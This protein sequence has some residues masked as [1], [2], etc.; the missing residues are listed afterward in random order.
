[1]QSQNETRKDKEI[2]EADQLLRKITFPFAFH[3]VQVK[4]SFYS[5]YVM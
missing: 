4:M 3:M 5:S 1:M 2:M